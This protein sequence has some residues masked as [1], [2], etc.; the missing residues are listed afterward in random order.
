MALPNEL[1]ELTSVLPPPPQNFSYTMLGAR[2]FSPGH[3]PLYCRDTTRT[4]PTLVIGTT[5]TGKTEL[6]LNLAFQDIWKGRFTIFIDGKCDEDTRNKLFYYSHVLAKRPFYMFLPYTEGGHLTNSW[7]PFVSSLLSA[8]KV[9]EMFISPYADYG[10][11]RGAGE[12]YIAAQ[13]DAF[14]SLMKALKSSGYGYNPQD[15]RFLLE[16][17]EL[18]SNLYKVLRNSGMT[19]YGHLMRKVGSETKKFRT[20]MEGFVNHLK[21]F[22][23]WSLNSYN[24]A[25]QL[26]RL[27]MTDA[28]VYVGLPVNSEPHLMRNVGNILVNQLKAL[29]A[30]VQTTEKT[31]RRAISCII[32]EAGTFID[33][34]L[35]EWIC[36]VRSSGFL[37]VLG[38]QNLAN[39]EGRRP[40][41]SKEIQSNAPNIMMFNPK[42]ADTAKWF[43][44]LSGQ[45]LK[46]MTTVNMEAAE[47][48]DRGSFRA[49]ETHRLPPDA[50]LSLNVGQFYYRSAEPTER[51]ILLSAPLM[52][53]PSPDRDEYRCRRIET[54]MLPELRGLNL[55]L[56]VK[57]M[58][59]KMGG[60]QNAVNQP[61]GGDRKF[62]RKRG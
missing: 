28:V 54:K 8:S 11:S 41:F 3:P 42:D 13:R 59:R 57:E 18:L 43:S 37:L 40:G 2:L 6:L 52:P 26:D 7:N 58:H 44:T 34:G 23:H 38:I 46:T 36:K 51:P 35:A 49:S 61:A 56:Q 5:G 19:H 24:P 17:I 12:Y 16:N 47:E 39:L 4:R 30:H 53:A 20:E 22:T 21:L 60:P 25:L 1:P 62:G 9:A 27:M 10:G 29:S 50:L 32:D 31:K 14:S 15:V 45:E 33:E 48:A 55:G